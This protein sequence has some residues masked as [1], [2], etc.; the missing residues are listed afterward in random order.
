M[1]EFDDQPTPGGIATF[2]D[3]EVQH[4]EVLKALEA[5][6]RAIVDSLRRH[7]WEIMRLDAAAASVSQSQHAKLRVE[8]LI[9]N[10]ITAGTL[11]LKV[12]E[13]SYDFDGAARSLSPIPF[14]LVI[15]RG[16]N[17]SCNGADGRIYMIGKP[18]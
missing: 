5:G 18:E 17:L 11:T 2:V 7:G 9:I 16:V 15:E 3:A 1:Q 12:G 8:L 13:A 14:P 4:Q 6:P 10:P